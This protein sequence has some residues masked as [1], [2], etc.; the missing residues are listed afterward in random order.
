MGMISVVGVLGCALA[1]GTPVALPALEALPAVPALPALEALAAPPA[2]KAIPARPALVAPS[3]LE[4]RP[5]LA[6]TQVPPAQQP[7]PA[8]ERIYGSVRTTEGERLEGYLRWDRNET[9]WADFLDG[10]REISREHEQE[11]E[12]LD[13]VL[14]ARRQRERSVTLPNVRITW[15]EDD[16]V[17]LE[18]TQAAVRFAHLA[19]LEVTGPRRAVGVL[20]SGDSVELVAGSTDLGGGFR[21]LVVETAGGGD[22]ELDWDELARVDFQSAPPGALP[23]KSRRLFGTLRTRDGRE[24]TGLVAW[25]L[26]EALTTDVLDGEEGREEVHIAFADIAAISR[27]SGSSA[28]VT[29]TN[30]VARVLEDTNDVDSSNRG[31]EITDEAFGRVV[32]RWDDFASLRFRAR[33][34]PAAGKDAF[35]ASGRVRGAVASA[36]GRRASGVIRWDNADE[37]RWDVLHATSDGMALTVELGQ[38]LSIAKGASGA[39]VTLVDGRVLEVE[40]GEDDAGDFREGNQGVFVEPASGTSGTAM[41]VPWRDL[42]TVTFER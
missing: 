37:H 26:D 19:S 38:V 35:V 31:I 24:F 20:T 2:L 36:D 9:H 33:T 14:R 12:R 23:P 7:D 18:T 13:A 15:D 29:L 5:G 21:G 6:A 17:P 40:I 28:R 3:G 30:G 41:M 25:D 11:A 42:L 16:G 22:V 8:S 39:L 32:L 27:E 1:L 34:G 10:R 4:A